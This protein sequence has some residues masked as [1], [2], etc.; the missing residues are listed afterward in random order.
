MYSIFLG[1]FNIKKVFSILVLNLGENKGSH[2]ILP[3]IVLIQSIWTQ[4]SQ[5]FQSSKTNTSKYGISTPPNPA[6]PGMSPH[7]KKRQPSMLQ[8]VRSVTF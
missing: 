4:W 7:L 1:L 2:L 5:C 8:N 6:Y 3:R